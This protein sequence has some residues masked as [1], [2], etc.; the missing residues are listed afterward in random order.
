MCNKALWPKLSLNYVRDIDE[1]V[2]HSATQVLFLHFFFL[3]SPAKKSLV[4]LFALAE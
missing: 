2:E 3:K 4:T 1:I